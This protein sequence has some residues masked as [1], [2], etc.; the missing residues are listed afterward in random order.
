M[1]WFSADMEVTRGTA[2]HPVPVVLWFCGS[3]R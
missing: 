1:A 3:D 2:P